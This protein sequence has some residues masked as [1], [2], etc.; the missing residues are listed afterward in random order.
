MALA[1][2]AAHQPRHRSAQVRVFNE[3]RGAIRVGLA[4]GRR[5]DDRLI[6]PGDDTTLA[7]PCTGGAALA[8]SGRGQVREYALDLGLLGFDTVHVR[9]TDLVPVATR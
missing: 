4:S 3:T 6:A 1:H 8:V 2:P 7:L 5:L 9:D